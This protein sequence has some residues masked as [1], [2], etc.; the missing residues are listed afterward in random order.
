MFIEEKDHNVNG[1]EL[2]K[3]VVF[4]A[5]PFLSTKISQKGARHHN[6]DIQDQDAHGP[7]TT[8]QA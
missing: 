4:L 5:I 6:N 7:Q 8:M 3:Q 1:L 2:Q